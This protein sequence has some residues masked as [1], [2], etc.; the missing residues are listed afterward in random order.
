M[1]CPPIKSSSFGV[2]LWDHVHDLV[3]SSSGTVAIG[4]DALLNDE[5][6]KSNNRKHPIHQKTEDLLQIQ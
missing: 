4:T 3:C 5:S 1:K 6:K 2:A